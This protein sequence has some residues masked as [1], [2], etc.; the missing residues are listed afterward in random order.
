MKL[1]FDCK[2]GFRV[3]YKFLGMTTFEDGWYFSYDTN[4]WQFYPSATAKGYSS[5]QRC[6]SVRAFR[7]KLKSAPKGV[8]FILESRWVGYNV[9]GYGSKPKNNIRSNKSA[10]YKFK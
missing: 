1:K 8:M 6:N 7:R 5:H 10:S 9:T 2:K 3:K 4:S